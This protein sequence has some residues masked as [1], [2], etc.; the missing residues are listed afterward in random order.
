MIVETS[1]HDSSSINWHQAVQVYMNT[2]ACESEDLQLKATLQLARVSKNAP[3]TILVATIPALVD[4]L[5]STPR[6][7]AAAA[8]ALGCIAPKYDGRLCPMI[9]QL[10]AI[11]SLVRLI[12]TSEEVF[13]KVL[14]R[15]LRALVSFDGPNREILMVSDGLEM[16][17]DFLC[18]CTD[19]RRRYLLEILS[20]LSMLRQV[21]RVLVGFGAIEFVVEA[22]S[23][24]K[25]ISRIRAA[26]TIGMVGIS[27]RVRHMLVENGVIPALVALFNEANSLDR[28]VAANAL[29]VISSHVDYLKPVA[30]G[31][32]ISLYVELLKG[33]EPLGKEIA[34]DAFCVLAVEEENAVMISE[35]M[36]RILEGNSEEAKSAALDILWDLSGYK[37]SISVVRASGAIPIMVGLLQNMDSDLKEKASGAIAQLSYD[38]ANREAIVE[39]GAIPVLINL[40]RGEPEELR[41]FAAECLLNFA[42]D[43]FYRRQVREAYSIPS[44]LAIQNRLI[45]IRASDEHVFRSMTM[46][47]A[48][49]QDLV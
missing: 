42:E 38:A 33:P 10:G 45:R 46:S 29:G 11:P 5:S 15:C 37:H 6:M 49:R 28:L 26:Q 21:R 24:G 8:Y 16:T 43:P 48:R 9:G 1:C 31:G 3:E 41:E 47:M 12:N 44:F 13:Q 39:A 35:Q 22:L 34:E 32:A 25:M 20:A 7:Q 36:V 4:L 2:I 23:N 40:L 14:L 19:E 30:Q 18:R 27:R 17:L